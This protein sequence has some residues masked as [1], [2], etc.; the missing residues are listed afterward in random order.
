MPNGEDENL[1]ICSN[2][3]CDFKIANK[4]LDALKA[5]LR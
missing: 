5:K 2:G 1:T 3:Q 4:K